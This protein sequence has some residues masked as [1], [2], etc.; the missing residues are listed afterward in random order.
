MLRT[1]EW[2]NASVLVDRNLE[3]GHAD[4]VAIF[5]GDEEI[6]YGELARRIN[7]FGHAL[8]GLGIGQ[9]DRVLLVLNDTPS[10]PVA[11]FGAIRIGAVPIP[12]NTLVDTDEY[13]FYVED[14]RTHMVVAD[15]EHHKKI[16]GAL[17]GVQEPVGL[18]LTNGREEGTH[19]FEDL[20]ESGEDELSPA[21][22]HKDDAAFWLYSSGSTGNPKG[23]VH[24]HH[25][26]DY[27]CETYARHVLG[28]RE[29][30][31]MLSTTKL[32]HAY[33]L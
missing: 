11:F 7:R 4:K 22:T 13:R 14:S 10:F 17:D 2:Y 6:T 25:D 31:V 5:Y 12:V 8:K 3:A 29:D 9:E 15:H 19:I 21:D 30:D 18:V 28:V 1:P 32:Q 24:L 16:R 23:V 33:G 26:I 20:L 27:T